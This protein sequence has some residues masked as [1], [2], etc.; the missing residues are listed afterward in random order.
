MPYSNTYKLTGGL[1][2]TNG[3]PI[4]SR[5]LVSSTEE[6]YSG[7]TWSGM[8][9]YNGMIVG[10]SDGYIFILKDKTKAIL[11][12]S[13]QTKNAWIEMAQAEVLDRTNTKVTGIE[14]QMQ[15][16][17]T[18]VNGFYVDFIS[19]SG[20][21]SDL[22][23]KVYRVIYNK[24]LNVSNRGYWES[25][26]TSETPSVT[27][28]DVG[29]VVIA[30]KEV[31]YENV[32]YSSGAHFVCIRPINGDNQSNRWFVMEKPLLVISAITSNS[33]ITA[34]S[35]ITSNSATTAVSAITSN[36]AQT[37]SGFEVVDDS[38]DI[39]Y[40]IPPGKG[41]GIIVRN[42]NT[43]KYKLKDVVGSIEPNESVAPSGKAISRVLINKGQNG[44]ISYRYDYVD[45]INSAKTTNS[46]ITSNSAITAV[47]SITSNSAQMLSGFEIVDKTETGTYTI[48]NGKS[49]GIIVQSGNSVEYK[50]QDVITNIEPN[51]SVTPSGKVVSRVLISKDVRGKVEYT[52]DYVDLINSATTC[53]SA[54]TSNSA[55]TALSATTAN[56]ANSANK[57]TTAED[58]AKINGMQIETVTFSEYNSP[59]FIKKEKTLYLLYES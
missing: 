5:I 28:V 39:T 50:L 2:I 24:A 14:T 29:S 17:I 8:P 32:K 53:N 19:L 37:L 13:A 34:N 23:S 52:Y 30:N 49:V 55:I 44:D 6:L 33:S 45:L 46:A 40:T 7:A 43:I 31:T 47:S 26:N 41:V 57:A 59:D 21:T 27:K 11:S 16:L 56:S 22:S 1:N 10:S 3:E 42:G 48:P 18:A 9:I 25:G 58:A 54:I 38:A 20:V 12:S 35:A 36:S 51:T 4:D 15:G